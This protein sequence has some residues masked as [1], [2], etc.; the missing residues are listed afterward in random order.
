MEQD[1]L[2]PL[3]ICMPVLKSCRLFCCC[4]SYNSESSLLCFFYIELSCLCCK[5]PTQSACPVT[6]IL[7]LSFFSSKPQKSLRCLITS[8]INRNS[9]ES[10]FFI[11][12]NLTK[13]WKFTS[14]LMIFQFAIFPA[15]N[16]CKN[17]QSSHFFE[18]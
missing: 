18:C 6:H 3:L 13:K 2:S 8:Y 11:F 16:H 10:R 5:N 12:I 14:P 9:K 4:L 17:Q 15:A 7:L 1:L